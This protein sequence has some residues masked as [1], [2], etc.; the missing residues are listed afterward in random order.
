MG[1]FVVR[2]PVNPMRYQEYVRLVLS[3]DLD[4]FQFVRHV[5][6][7]IAV[8]QVKIFAYGNAEDACGFSCFG[9]ACFGRSARTEFASCEVQNAHR[10]LLLYK[11]CQR[12]AATEFDIVGVCTDGENVQFHSPFQENVA[13]NITIRRSQG[14][15]VGYVA[16][17]VDIGSRRSRQKMLDLFSQTES[18]QPTS[19]AVLTVSQLTRRIKQVLETGFSSVSVQGE[20]SNFKLHSSGHMYFAIKDAGATLSAVIWRSRVPFL[21][22]TPE[23]G[24]KVIATGRI[25]VYEV[26]GNYQMDVISMRPVGEGELQIAF[27]KLKRKLATEGLFD[28]EHK[29][30]IPK[31]PERIGLVTSETGA[32]LQD[33]LHILRRRFPAVEVILAPVRVQG[34]GAGAEIAQAIRDFNRFGEVDVLIVCRGGGSL[35]DLWAFNEEIVARAIYHSRVPVI[36]A[37]GHEIDFTIADFVADLRAPTPSAAAELVVPDRST[38]LATVRDYWYTMHDNVRHVLNS[39]KERI[40]HLLRSYAFNRP[41]DLLR[42]YS[43]RVDELERSMTAAMKHTLSMR[44]ARIESLR[45]EL[46]ALDPALVLRRGYAI[47]RKEG[48]IIGSRTLLKRNDDIDITFHDGT[49]SSRVL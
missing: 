31:Y 25:T 20:I 15:N 9:L 1:V 40:H 27:E 36:S 7:E 45:H 32:A 21:S 48:Q 26:R 2:M 35:E 28:E 41:L 44:K 42:Q 5:D 49:V 6:F 19:P 24:M 33:I 10:L 23:D 43:Q 4:D 14:K 11:L 3:N 38:L 22:F 46:I 12:T 17:I 37:V 13:Q 47:V 16:R 39:R 30:P 8:G 29:K 18:Q 34:A